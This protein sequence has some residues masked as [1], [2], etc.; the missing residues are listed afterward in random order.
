MAW[1]SGPFAF[2]SV[3]ELLPW[4]ESGAAA[5]RA[6]RVHFAARAGSHPGPIP[7]RSGQAPHAGA[8]ERGERR[9][10][11]W[12]RGVVPAVPRQV[13][14]GARQRHPAPAAGG[15]LGSWARRRGG[16][17]ARLGAERTSRLPDPEI[18][19]G[20]GRAR[21]GACGVA[22][23]PRSRWTTCPLPRP[24]LAG[25]TLTRSFRPPAGALAAL[26]NLPCGKLAAAGLFG[27]TLTPHTR[28][29]LAFPPSLLPQAWVGP[30]CLRPACPTVGATHT[31]SQ[32]RGP[33]LPSR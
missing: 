7:T 27:A 18:R 15:A 12:P 25:E 19:E 3:T 31:F 5:A 9:G 6:R 4:P 17:R 30:Y 21:A 13:R 1:L 2:C 16:G 32:G 8:D 23:L 28:V 14:V 33:H 22:R 20:R 26:G 11:E 24:G 29:I 10:G